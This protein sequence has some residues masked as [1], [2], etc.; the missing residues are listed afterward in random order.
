MGENTNAY[1]TVKL[2]EE[3]IQKLNTALTEMGY[4]TADAPEFLLS[5][6]AAEAGHLEEL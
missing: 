2:K 3:G 6:K 1:I 4:V 5:I